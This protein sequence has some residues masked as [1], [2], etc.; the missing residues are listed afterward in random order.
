MGT[1]P[2]AAIRHVVAEGADD[3]GGDTEGRARQGR[4]AEPE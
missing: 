1:K 3:E 2:A 4:D